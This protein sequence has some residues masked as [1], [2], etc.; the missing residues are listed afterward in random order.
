M[1]L[2]SH[3]VTKF[4]KQ[5]L[6]LTTEALAGLQWSSEGVCHATSIE[7][8]VLSTLFQFFFG[9][10]N[11]YRIYIKTRIIVKNRVNSGLS[12]LQVEGRP[13]RAI[14]HPWPISFIRS[15]KKWHDQSFIF[16][17]FTLP[18][19]PQPVLNNLVLNSNALNLCWNSSF[20]KN[21]FCRCSHLQQ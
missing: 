5:K 7:I 11:P 15:I 20:A 6:L 1:L 18:M 9:L 8:F 13:L 17:S 21:R 4:I 12:Y 16:H 10:K 19:E 14:Y 3:R 2:G